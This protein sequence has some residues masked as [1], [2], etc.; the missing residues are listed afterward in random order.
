MRILIIVNNTHW[1]NCNFNGTIKVLIKKKK[2]TELSKLK[3]KHCVFVRE[4]RL[5]TS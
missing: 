3:E 5:K 2:M 4:Y 1:K